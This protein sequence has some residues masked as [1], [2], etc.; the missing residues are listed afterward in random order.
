MH[1]E[2]PPG[3][4]LAPLRAPELVAGRKRSLR[5]RGVHSIVKHH[6]AGNAR[7]PL[8]AQVAEQRRAAPPNTP[9]IYASKGPSDMDVFALPPRK[10][11][12]LPP[13]LSARS[14]VR[15]PEVSQWNTGKLVT[16]SVDYDY[17][18]NPPKPAS[19]LFQ[20][21][22]PAKLDQAPPPRNFFIPA[23]Q[24]MADKASSS[25]AFFRFS[26]TAKADT[27]PSSEN[28]FQLPSQEKANLPIASDISTIPGAPRKRSPELASSQTYPAVAPGPVL[29]PLVQKVP[30]T[31]KPSIFPETI[32]PSNTGP[33]PRPQATIEP[34]SPFIFKHQVSATPSTPLTGPGAPFVFKLGGASSDN[35][36]GTAPHKLSSA[37]PHPEATR[38]PPLKSLEPNSTVI[39][40]DSVG[41]GEESSLEAHANTNP[42]GSDNISEEDDATIESLHNDI[43][44]IRESVNNLKTE[45]SSIDSFE[46]S[47]QA[48]IVMMMLQKEGILREI[49]TKEVTM[50]QIECE[51]HNIKAKRDALKQ[52]VSALALRTENVVAEAESLMIA[53]ESAEAGRPD[54]EMANLVED[55]AQAVAE[56]EDSSETK[57]PQEQSTWEVSEVPP[58]EFIEEEYSGVKGQ[59]EV[60]S[61]ARPSGEAQEEESLAKNHEKDEKHSDQETKET[62]FPRVNEPFAR[63]NFQAAPATQSPVKPE[64]E[65]TTNNSHLND[66][67]IQKTTEDTPLVEARSQEH[68]SETTQESDASGSFKTQPSMD[69]AEKKR[70]AD[71]KAREKA[72][73]ERAA[74]IEAFQQ[75]EKERQEIKRLVKEHLERV[76][77]EES[78]RKMGKPKVPSTD[79]ESSDEKES[80]SPIKTSRAAMDAHK[81]VFRNADQGRYD[82]YQSGGETGHEMVGET[83]LRKEMEPREEE[84][85]IVVRGSG[86]PNQATSPK[87]SVVDYAASEHGQSN[88]KRP[89]FPYHISLDLRPT[90][91]VDPLRVEVGLNQSPEEEITKRCMELMTPAGYQNLIHMPK[92]RMFLD[93]CNKR[94]ASRLARYHA[95]GRE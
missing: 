56:E 12:A 9:P 49:E 51:L 70:L 82:L 2:G 88:P 13:H 7:I 17:L 69:N 27:G 89:R 66:M 63:I 35:S 84:E 32:F 53:K 41:R 6:L 25:G 52:A 1:S 59:L 34:G 47:L 57:G 64:V 42:T 14:V 40:K 23:D 95:S 36:A 24:E 5:S 11:S 44:A 21:P 72:Q 37:K 8:R 75:A 61:E 86:A 60:T 48:R 91:E 22:T 45:V 50:S 55:I 4:P 85:A 94:H 30:E 16:N 39:N 76:K 38:T 92:L 10:T 43:S 19:S 65:I 68:K 62:K 26:E 90:Y 33:I 78:R 77:H 28:K 79:D 58:N 83:S 31:P 73:Q 87:N 29:F 81:A 20:S 54:V 46:Q 93:Q 67:S 74:E 15:N 80:T 3:N 71:L 18:S